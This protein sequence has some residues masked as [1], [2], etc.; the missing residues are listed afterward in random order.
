MSTRK[1]ESV[2]KIPLLGDIPILGAAFRRKVK[3]NEKTELMIFL[4]PTI[5]QDP[6]TL[7]MLTKEEQENARIPA[8]AFSE[9]DLERFLNQ[10]P[11]EGPRSSEPPPARK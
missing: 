11:E 7:A 6:R 3:E 4:T 2:S 8:N 9:G 1:T 5:V 10:K